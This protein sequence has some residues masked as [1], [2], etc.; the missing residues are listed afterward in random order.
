MGTP[1]SGQ[2]KAEETVMTN[3]N[4]D[5]EDD[6]LG[7]EIELKTSQNKEEE[8]DLGDETEREGTEYQDV[9]VLNIHRP[10]VERL[11]KKG[12]QSLHDV[13]GF[14]KVGL[15]NRG[16]TMGDVQQIY[17]EMKREGFPMAKDEV[18]IL[19]EYLAGH[20]TTMRKPIPKLATVPEGDLELEEIP[21]K[22]HWTQR[23]E[24]QNRLRAHMKKLAAGRL[25]KANMEKPVVGKNRTLGTMFNQVY[26][27]WMSELGI[28]TVAELVKHSLKQLNESSQHRARVVS[29]TLAVYGL[30]LRQEGKSATTR[31]RGR[32]T[33]IKKTK[34]TKVYVEND[35]Q[36]FIGYVIGYA[37]ADIT[38]R[39]HEFAQSTGGKI[40]AAELTYRLGRLLCRKEGGEVLG[41]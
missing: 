40:S 22:L 5:N 39:I 8:P 3:I 1:T 26:L 36:E 31:A 21:K 2:S 15:L 16:F 4:P 17:R 37:H 29:R 41:T 6:I 18:G 34:E 7:V 9:S 33:S 35:G 23:P 11:H 10:V 20:K 14:S 19:S 12:F 25:A 24:N 13:Q 30:K 32:K 27:E 28:T 38:A